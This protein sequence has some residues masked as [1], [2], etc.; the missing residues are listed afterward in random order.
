MF[1]LSCFALDNISSCLWLHFTDLYYLIAL[2][3]PHMNK[4]IV[5]DS[6]TGGSKVSRFVHY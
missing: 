5:V 1:A 3:A 2:A 4:S 6:S